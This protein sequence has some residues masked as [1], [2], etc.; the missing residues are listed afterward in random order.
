MRIHQSGCATYD[1]LVL[2]GKERGHVWCDSRAD[3]RGI[4]PERP[5]NGRGRVTFGR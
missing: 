2:T 3:G 4:F 1:L 5:A